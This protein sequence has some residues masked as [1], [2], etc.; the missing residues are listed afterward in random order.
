MGLMCI[1]GKKGSLSE[2]NR[3][4]PIMCFLYQ[5]VMND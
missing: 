5:G 3:M 4:I 2:E 1:I